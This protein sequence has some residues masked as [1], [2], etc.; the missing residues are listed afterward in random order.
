M[1]DFHFP[2]EEPLDVANRNDPPGL[3]IIPLD[4]T[5]ARQMTRHVVESTA[6][7]SKSRGWIPMVS[8]RMQHIPLMGEGER[9]TTQVIMELNDAMTFVHAIMEGI[10]AAERDAKYGLREF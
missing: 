10:K 8:I 6:V 7:H 3:Q 4:A 2:E 1:T 9:V 5:H